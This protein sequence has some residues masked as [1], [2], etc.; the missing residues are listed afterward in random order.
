MLVFTNQ[1]VI[2]SN[3]CIHLYSIIQTNQLWTFVSNESSL[4]VKILTHLC[5]DE[6]ITSKIKRT[7]P[8]K[9]FLNIFVDFI[10]ETRIFVN[11][12]NAVLLGEFTTCVTRCLQSFL[13]LWSLSL[14]LSHISTLIEK[15]YSNTCLLGQYLI[16]RNKIF[17]TYGQYK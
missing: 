12:N 3:T 6:N 17:M 4:N 8:K 13:I 2:P 10:Y 14:S 5:K 11:N 7:L 1:H 9:N 16:K 15:T